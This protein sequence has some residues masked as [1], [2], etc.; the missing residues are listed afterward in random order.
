M[1]SVATAVFL[2]TKIH[3]AVLLH[4]LIFLY[5]SI[6]FFFGPKCEDADFEKTSSAPKMTTVRKYSFSQY[7]CCSRDKIFIWS[8][9][10]YY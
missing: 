10:L 4:I 8:K 9:H 7:E 2:I 3:G 1:R 5:I 6:H